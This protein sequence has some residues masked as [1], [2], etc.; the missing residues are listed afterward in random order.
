MRFS[1]PMI[2]SEDILEKDNGGIQEITER[3]RTVS[4]FTVVVEREQPAAAAC[5]DGGKE[6]AAA[7]EDEAST[8]TE[9]LQR[10]GK[11]CPLQNSSPSLL[12]SYSNR[13]EG[14]SIDGIRCSRWLLRST[15][16]RRSRGNPLSLK[17]EPSTPTSKR[18]RREP[19]T[20]SSKR[21]RRDTSSPT[22]TA[23]SFTGE[24]SVQVVL[25]LLLSNID[26]IRHD[27]NLR[28]SSHCSKV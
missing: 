28:I 22:P 7:W 8:C 15:G 21:K 14:P 13:M 25:F 10:M 1:I 20:P 5:E 11:G 18:K 17:F 9:E 2:K 26:F 16:V 23:N 6:A 19:S 24:N 12:S 4:S 27:M 3:E